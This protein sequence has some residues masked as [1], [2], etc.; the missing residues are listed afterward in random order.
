MGFMDTV[1]SKV[2]SKKKE[3]TPESDYSI[4]QARLDR[5]ASD[6]QEDKEEAIAQKWCYVACQHH[7]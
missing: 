7:C 4:T 2:G 6:A 1:R 5:A 3:K